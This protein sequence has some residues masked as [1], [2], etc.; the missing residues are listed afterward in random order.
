[1]SSDPQRSGPREAELDAEQELE[2]SRF[3]WTLVARWWLLALGLALGILVGYLVSLGGGRVYQARAVVYLGQPLS[4]SSSGQVQSQATNPSVVSAIVKSQSVVNAVAAQVGVPPGKLRAGISSGAVSGN[5]ARS[6][7]TPLVNI[8]VRGPWRKQA[9]EAANLL[10]ER[11]IQGVSS[12]PR[13]KIAALQTQLEAQTQEIDALDANVARYQRAIEGS[14]LSTG[15]RLT[16]VGLLNA[17]QV[18]RGQAVDA[19]VQ[20]Q[21]QLELARNV[22]QG[23]VITRAAATKVAAR[24]RGTSMIVGGIIGLLAGVAAA[25]AWEP[26]VRRLAA[27]RAERPSR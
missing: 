20:T 10:A 17:A 4:P 21:L 23:Q 8:T 22:E 19:R 7:Q 16:L 25:L 18:A 13:A 1:V 24:G 5:V 11:V 2:I 6:G 15:E 12:Y 14:G 26:A 3:W 9:A 27:R